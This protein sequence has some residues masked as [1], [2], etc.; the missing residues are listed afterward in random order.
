MATDMRDRIAS[1]A[2]IGFR[3]FFN[4]PIAIDQRVTTSDCPMIVLTIEG[5]AYHVTITKARKGRPG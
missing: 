2:I 4:E 3:R 5:V 1:A